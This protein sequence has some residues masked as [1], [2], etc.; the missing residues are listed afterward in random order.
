MTKEKKQKKIKPIYGVL[1]LL[2]ILCIVLIVFLIIQNNKTLTPDYAPGTIDENAIKEQDS[3]KKM[4]V[5][6]GGGA[7]S[8]SYSNVASVDTKNKTVKM[9]F[10]N[11]S[12]SRESIVLEIVVTQKDKEYVIAK[13]DLLPPGYALYK[14]NLDSKVK[15]PKGGYKGKFRTTYYNEE[16]GEKE[17]VNTEIELSIEVK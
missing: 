2:I 8:I 7:V 3:G 6:S 9:Y 12:I 11:P 10:K 1:G 15:L 16:T 4:D 13:S 5:S 17:I 14:M